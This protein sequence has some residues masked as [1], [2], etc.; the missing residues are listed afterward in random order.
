M[1]RHEVY[2]K[3][4]AERKPV[5]II[6]ATETCFPQNSSKTKQKKLIFTIHNWKREPNLSIV[7]Q[8]FQQFHQ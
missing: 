2:Y 5:V 8:K 1:T 4:E 7:L 6:E 3:K